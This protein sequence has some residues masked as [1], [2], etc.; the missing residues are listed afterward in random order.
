[1]TSASVRYGAFA[2]FVAA[3]AGLAATDV[4]DVERVDAEIP[5]VVVDEIRT[6]LALADRITNGWN[7]PTI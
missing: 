5:E 4:H 1:M 6:G 7:S 2:D 3:N